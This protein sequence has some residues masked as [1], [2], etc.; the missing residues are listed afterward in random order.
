MSELTVAPEALAAA[1]AARLIHDVAG[2]ASGLTSGLE[3]AADATDASL[4][5]EG[6]ALAASSAQ[7][8]LDLLGFCRVAFGVGELQSAAGLGALAQS[9]FLGR[10]AQLDWAPS[11]GEFDRPSAQAALILLQAAAAGLATGGVARLT[12]EARSGETLIRVDGEGPRLRLQPEALDGLAGKPLA[13]GIQGRWAPGYFLFV[14]LARL[15]GSVSVAVGETA[16][17]LQARV[18]AGPA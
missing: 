10:R 12:A 6:L 3:L 4:R 9:H 16:F 5:A 11:I 18:P 17:I 1:V 2:P 14:S 15:G 7:A 8:L 13:G